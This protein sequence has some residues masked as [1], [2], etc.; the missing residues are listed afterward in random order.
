MLQRQNYDGSAVAP[1]TV[2]CS[3]AHCDPLERFNVS[4]SLGFLRILLDAQQQHLQGVDSILDVRDTVE[5]GERPAHVFT[6]QWL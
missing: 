2:S 5:D 3:V 4:A 6:K 1:P